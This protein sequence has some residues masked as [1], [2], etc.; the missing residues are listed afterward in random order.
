MPPKE[1][2]LR[3]SA[4]KGTT[5]GYHLDFI[6]DTMDIMDGL[7]EMRESLIVMDNAPIHASDS[8]DPIIE[9]RGYKHVYLPPYS[10]ESNPIE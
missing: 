8:I 1:N 5:S 4:P 6:N 10:P 7:P 3:I 2:Y 9:K